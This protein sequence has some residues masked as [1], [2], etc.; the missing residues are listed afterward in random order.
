MIEQKLKEV[1]LSEKEVIVYLCIFQY[2]KIS[3][4]R[5]ATVTS[6]NR[7]TVYS[8]AKELIKKGL[9]AEDVS[10]SVKYFLSLG[11]ESLENLV[12]SQEQKIV[13]LKK[14]L[15]EIVT[16][17]KQFP[18][19]GSYSIPKIRYIDESRLRDFLISQSAVWAKSGETIDN[20]WWGFQDHTLLENYEDWAD[21]FFAHFTEETKIYLLTNKKVVETKTMKK[22]SYAPQRHIKY[23]AGGALFTAT[24]VVIGDYIL[25]IIT[26][27]HPHYLIEIQDKTMAQNIRELYKSIWGLI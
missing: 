21:Y 12:I 3:P 10:G 26:G 23:W 8:V 1:G 13:S 18:R 15:P 22:K 5:I 11:E 20:T 14:K 2:Q 19:K 25:M 16:E 4:A 7:P 17:L 9:I 24:H 27:E 6:I